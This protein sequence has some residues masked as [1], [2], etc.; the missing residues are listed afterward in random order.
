VE[1]G[2]TQ[3]PT[4]S[5]GPWSITYLHNFNNYQIP[6]GLVIDKN[7]TIYGITDSYPTDPPSGT[8]FRIETQ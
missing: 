2:P 5:G 1:T 4:T 3:P 7:G 8:I 6:V